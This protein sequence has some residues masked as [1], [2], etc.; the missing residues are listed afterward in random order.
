MS[1]DIVGVVEILFNVGVIIIE[2][3]KIKVLCL[4]CFLMDLG[5]Y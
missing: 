3:N 1:D 5:C 2:V 4:I